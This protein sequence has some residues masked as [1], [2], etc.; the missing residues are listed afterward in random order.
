[1]EQTGF[2]NR[3]TVCLEWYKGT[4]TR[5][6]PLWT[7]LCRFLEKTQN[8]VLFLFYS[9]LLSCDIP[10]LKYIFDPSDIIFKEVASLYQCFISTARTLTLWN[11]IFELPA[12]CRQNSGATRIT[13]WTIEPQL[14]FGHWKTQTVYLLDNTVNMGHISVSINGIFCL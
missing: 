4:Q 12:Y 5:E 6:K 13:F 1:M 7:C 9:A 11:A 8:F 3:L 2:D 14:I 10:T